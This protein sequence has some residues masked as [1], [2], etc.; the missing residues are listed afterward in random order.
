VA[1]GDLQCIV[2]RLRLAQLEK[3]FATDD[4]FPRDPET[5]AEVMRRCAFYAV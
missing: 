3:T 2:P 4:P 5:E 1:G